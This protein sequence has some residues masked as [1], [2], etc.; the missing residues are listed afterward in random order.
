MCDLISDAIYDQLMDDIRDVIID[1]E[2]IKFEYDDPT[3]DDAIAKLEAILDSTYREQIL[4]KKWSDD[5]V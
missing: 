2:E 4:L 1:L 3:V 5:N